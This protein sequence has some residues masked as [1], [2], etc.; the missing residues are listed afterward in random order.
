MLRAE[1]DTP[2][3]LEHGPVVRAKLLRY[4][5]ERHELVFTAHHLVCDGSSF[6][7]VVRDLAALY[8]E[9]AEGE[10]AKLAP[11]TPFS[12]FAAWQEEQARHA[13]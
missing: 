11:A 12:A 8:T 7:T 9:Y 6:G 10:P 13:R 2:F 5:T 1:C 4:E 3:D